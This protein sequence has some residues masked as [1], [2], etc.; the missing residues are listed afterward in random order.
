MV[1]TSALESTN[2]ILEN[3]GKPVIKGRSDTWSSIY[4]QFKRLGYTH[5]QAAEMATIQDDEM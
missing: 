2:A 5:E 3:A 4:N 1:K